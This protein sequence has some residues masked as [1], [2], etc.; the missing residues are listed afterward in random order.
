[1]LLAPRSQPSRSDELRELTRK[2]A[3]IFKEKNYEPAHKLVEMANW[4]LKEIDTEEDKFLR[5]RYIQELN[6]IN[7][8]LL[9]YV[10]PKLK[11][12]DIQGQIDSNITV[13]VGIPRLKEATTTQPKPLP[14]AD[15]N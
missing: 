15:K 1:M 7:K 9:G 5:L 8:E 13:V 11:S 3:V 12:I 4:L 10:Y 2:L 14:M 6:T